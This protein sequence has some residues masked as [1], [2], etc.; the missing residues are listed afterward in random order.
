VINITAAQSFWV[1]VGVGMLLAKKDPNKPLKGLGA[2][3][4]MLFLAP[5]AA[6]VLLSELY[7]D[8]FTRTEMNVKIESHWYT[9]VY[10]DQGSFRFPELSRGRL[11]GRL[12]LAFWNDLGVVSRSKLVRGCSYRVVVTFGGLFERQPLK[13]NRAP[14]LNKIVQVM[15]PVDG[16]DVSCDVSA[17]SGKPVCRDDQVRPELKGMPTSYY[18]CDFETYWT[19]KRLEFRKS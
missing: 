4:L 16:S 9:D 7:V 12:H 3:L 13:E 5:L 6:I 10:T 11:S 17:K 19:N 2:F 18:N 1:L 15:G 14:P 8:A